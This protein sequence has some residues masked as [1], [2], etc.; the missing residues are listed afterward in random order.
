[1]GWWLLNYFQ[2]M[3]NCP[4]PLLGSLSS[5]SLAQSLFFEQRESI[6]VQELEI[7]SPWC[8]SAAVPRH[9]ARNLL[10]P[11]PLQLTAPFLR[12]L[13]QTQILEYGFPDHPKSNYLSHPLV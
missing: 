3:A 2:A 6:V 5:A 4:K 13:L 9:S 12:P 7:C 1:M 11:A 10:H 8:P